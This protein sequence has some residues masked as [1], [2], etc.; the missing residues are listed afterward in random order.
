MRLMRIRQ[1]LLVTAIRKMGGQLDVSKRDAYDSAAFDVDV[2][3]I[4]DGFRVSLKPA[5][6]R[7]KGW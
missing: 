1:A 6:V 5:P 7:A 2:S 3:D 4:D